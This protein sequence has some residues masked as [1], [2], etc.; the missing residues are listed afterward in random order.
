MVELTSMES[1]PD[2]KYTLPHKIITGATI[3]YV[4]LGA[5]LWVTVPPYYDRL[6]GRLI[7]TPA[8]FGAI[9]AHPVALYYYYKDNKS[10]EQ[11]GINPPTWYIYIGLSFLVTGFVTAPLYLL[12][13]RSRIANG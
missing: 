12:Q 5:I 4:V 7:L 2:G 3:I 6:I 1:E 13:R 8:M 11:H 10:L 9:L